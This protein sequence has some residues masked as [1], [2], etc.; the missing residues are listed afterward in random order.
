[1]TDLALDGSA[2]DGG[3][4]DWFITRA[5][6]APHWFDDLVSGYA[7]F[8]LGVFAL[9]MLVGWWRARAGLQ[10]QR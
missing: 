3:L 10:G 1:V 7:S 2:I 8:G 9:L 6:D 4:Y 5:A